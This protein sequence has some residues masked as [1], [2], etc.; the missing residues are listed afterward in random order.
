MRGE[1]WVALALGVT[2]AAGG[3]AAAGRLRETG[4]P[5]SLQALPVAAPPVATPSATVP[6]LPPV[7][8]LRPLPSV[9]PTSPPVTL[10][11][12]PPAPTLPVVTV[13]PPTR[14]PKPP[15]VQTGHWRQTRDGVTVNVRMTPP[16]PRAG[17]LTTWTIDL[18]SPGKAC[19][20]AELLFSDGYGAPEHDDYCTHETRRYERGPRAGSVTY[21]HA[22]RRPGAKEAWINVRASCDE[23]HYFTFR[24]EFEVVEGPVLSN[25]PVRPVLW[26]L[27]DSVAHSGADPDAGQYFVATVYDHDGMPASWWWD[28]GDGTRTPVIENPY[29]CRWPKDGD[30]VNGRATSYLAHGYTEPGTYTVRFHATTA[31]CDGEDPQTVTGTLPWTVS[32]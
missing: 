11:P 29:A 22:F 24:P 3:G 25:G 1:Q 26:T 16:V 20:F 32:D 6:P 7:R 30:W 12:L 19:C 10:P 5:A 8:T 28:W 18:V 2:L 31:G 9:H 21:T 14:P 23:G 4:A 17:Q 13:A 27:D 15:P